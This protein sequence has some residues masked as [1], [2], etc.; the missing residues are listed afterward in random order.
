MTCAMRTRQVL[1]RLNNSVKMQLCLEIRWTATCSIPNNVNR[2]FK[3][4]H[5][6]KQF[7]VRTE[8]ATTAFQLHKPNLAFSRLL[9]HTTCSN[10]LPVA[11]CAL[12]RSVPCSSPKVLCTQSRILCLTCPG[13]MSS[14]MQSR[15]HGLAHALSI[16]FSKYHETELDLAERGFGCTF[17]DTAVGQMTSCP[18]AC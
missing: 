14:Y 18:E 11:K 17:W 10:L 5:H 16:C 4:C 13:D 3:S 9:I 8:T 2:Y 1:A 15:N 12:R 7:P 6:F